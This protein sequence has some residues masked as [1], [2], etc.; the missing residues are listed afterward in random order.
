MPLGTKVGL[1]PS[2]IVLDGDPAPR[3]KGHSRPHFSAHFALAR[4]PMSATAEF[5]YLS[6]VASSGQLLINE[7]QSSNVYFVALSLF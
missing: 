4:S 6:C 7:Y 2:D 5:L 1:G 3:G